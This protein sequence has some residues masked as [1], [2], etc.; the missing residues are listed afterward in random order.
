MI[1]WLVALASA[2]VPATFATPVR[3]EVAWNGDIVHLRLIGRSAQPVRVHYRLSA[4]DGSNRTEQSGTGSLSNAGDTTLL[5][6]SQQAGPNWRAFVEITVDGQ[7]SYQLR[8][9]RQSLGQDV[10]A[11]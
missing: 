2:A 5:D 10:A 4:G 8:L 6:L 7:R 9:D 3:A 11:P 1:G